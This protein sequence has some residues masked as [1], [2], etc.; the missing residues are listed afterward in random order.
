MAA[1]GMTEMMTFELVD[2]GSLYRRF[3]RSPDGRIAVHDPRSQDHSILRDS[4]IPS[5]M[6]ALS[7]NVKEDYPQ[8]VFEIGRVYARSA[9][10]VKESWSLCCLVAHSQASFTEAKMYLAAAIRVLTGIEVLT[11]ARPHW[12]FSEG[13]SAAVSARGSALGHAGELKPEALAA[14][15]LNVPVSGF[16]VDLS[17]LFK[18]LK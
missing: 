12:A 10:G 18:L 3:G 2:E 13:R 11:K 7:G 17:L 8:R 5:I 4:L 1:A 15:G 9:G 14:F 6:A 16:E